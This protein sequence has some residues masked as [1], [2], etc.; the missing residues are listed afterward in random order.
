MSTSIRELRG[1]N[2]DIDLIP[3]PEL[4]WKR[5]V[6]PWNEAEQSVEHKCAVKDTSICRYFRDQACRHRPVHVSQVGGSALSNNRVQQTTR[7]ARVK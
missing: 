1:G 5:E 4:T 6:C 7:S 2:M 3:N